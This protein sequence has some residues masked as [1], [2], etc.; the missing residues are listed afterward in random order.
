MITIIGILLGL[1]LP[2]MQAAREASRRSQCT[3]NLRQL[4]IAIQNY[5][6][7]FKRFPPGA[8]MHKQEQQNSISWRVMILP[9]M[10]ETTLY[11]QI[12]PKTDGGA[13]NWAAQV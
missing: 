2:A 4:G 9:F 5:H 1:L 10:E 13:T 7:Q 6:G 12:R 8:H 11:D 3:N